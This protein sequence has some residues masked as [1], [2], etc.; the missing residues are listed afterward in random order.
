MALVEITGSVA[1]W[2]K[3]LHDGLAGHAHAE[4]AASFAVIPPFAEA[5]PSTADCDRLDEYIEDR[6]HLL[7]GLLAE[8]R[9]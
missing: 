2:T 4:A 5:N 7:Q 3:R 1:R 8:D 6:M 9:A